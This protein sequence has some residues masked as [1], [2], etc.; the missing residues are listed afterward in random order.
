MRSSL[1]RRITNRVL[2]GLARSGFGATNVR[3][4][5]HRLR[6]A[7]IGENVFIGDDVYLENEYP[8]AIEIQS[9]VQVSVRAIILAHTRGLGRIVIERDV[10]IGPNTV[11]ATS[12]NR[13]LRI[14]EGAVIGAGVI[15]TMDVP[16]RTF[17]AN[18]TSKPRARVLVPLTKAETMDD[19]VRGL[20]PIARRSKAAKAETASPKTTML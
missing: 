19:F 8:E 15:V 12:G 14:G 18:E 20:A 7:K 5:L 13:T 3:P 9:G 10:F 2:H 1:F 6:G 4:L 17:V 11:I 16:A